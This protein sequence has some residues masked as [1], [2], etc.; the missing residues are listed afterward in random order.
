MMRYTYFFLLAFVLMACSPEPSNNVVKPTPKPATST[1]TPVPTA[2]PSPAEIISEAQIKAI[3]TSKT[4][5]LQVN[6]ELMLIG[7]IQL[8]NGVKRSFDQVQNLIK[9][10]NNHPSL[11]SLDLKNRL[12]KALKAG[13]ATVEI[14][15][16][17]NPQIKVLI[18]VK[19]APVTP[20]IDPNVALVD[21]EIQ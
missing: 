17:D 7:D 8:D 1:A 4:L 14:A 9:I 11:L 3:L 15:S 2:T 5:D 21:V 10:K 20:G 18:N 16:L 19:I 6:E 12:I 13:T